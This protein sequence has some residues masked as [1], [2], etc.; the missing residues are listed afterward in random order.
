[1]R[2]IGILS[3]P[4]KNKPLW[5]RIFRKITVKEQ[6]GRYVVAEFAVGYKT[7]CRM[8]E[9]GRKRYIKKAE[10]FFQSLGVD[11]FV[12]EKKLLGYIGDIPEHNS[13]VPGEKIFD[14]ILFAVSKTQEK[15]KNLV[16]ADR[17]L[18][19]VCYDNLRRICGCAGMITLCT[20]EEKTAKEISD[21]MMY[22]YGICLNTVS[23][24]PEPA[25]AVADVDEG[26]VRIGDFVIDGAEFL[27][28]S[29]EYEV[30]MS[31]VAGILGEDSVIEIKNWLSGKNIIKIS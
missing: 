8:R 21:R 4:E 11:G 14:C 23:K 12:A 10:R 9:F 28:D 25:R 3:V 22:D 2:R 1:M 13:N 7:F 31:S 16:I 20:D 30:D 29:G 5:D 6:F 17:K 26:Y 18:K 27:N 19:T 15:I 24:M